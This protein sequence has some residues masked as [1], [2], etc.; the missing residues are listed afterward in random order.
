VLAAALREAGRPG[1]AAG[2]LDEL[3]RTGRL[4]ALP[5]IRAGVLEQR[6]HLVAAD[7]PDR[8]PAHHHEA[9][10]LRADLGLAPECIDSLEALAG[11]GRAEAGAALL[12]AAAAAR[13]ALGYAAR[14][15]PDPAAALA[16]DLRPALERGRAM[17]LDTAIA[18][19]G[20]ARGPRGRPDSGWASLT[21]AERS[22]VDRAVR[23]LSNPQIAAELF[24]SPGTVKTHLAHVYTKL[25]VRNRTELATAWSRR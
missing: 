7:H 9:L 20:R 15:G 24:V 19:A 23:G 11:A 5:R 3:E 12:G 16:D 1:Q 4:D 17:D 21:P 22:V 2:V 13:A 14:T 10:R 6:A 18:L 8:A 25:G